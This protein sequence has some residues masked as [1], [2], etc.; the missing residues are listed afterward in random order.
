MIGETRGD[1]GVRDVIWGNENVPQMILV[2]HNYE[3]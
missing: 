2:M 3:Y 1:S